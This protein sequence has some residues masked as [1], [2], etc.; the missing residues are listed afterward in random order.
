[1]VFNG[2]KFAF[3]MVGFLLFAVATYFFILYVSAYYRPLPDQDLYEGLG[4][5][6]VGAI[7]TAAGF[8]VEP[9]KRASDL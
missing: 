6:I 7:F 2:T 4:S 8:A 9:E 3:L 1:M 5:A